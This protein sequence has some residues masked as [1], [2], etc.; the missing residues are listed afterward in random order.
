M[1]RRKQCFILFILIFAN[2]IFLQLLLKI[3]LHFYAHVLSYGKKKHP[4]I[5]WVAEKTFLHFEIFLQIIH[6][7]Q[8]ISMA[9]KVYCVWCKKS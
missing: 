9:I 2:D 5:F 4:E 3:N 8:N 7:V 1:W 6:S